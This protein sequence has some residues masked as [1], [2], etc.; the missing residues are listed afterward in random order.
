V[1]RFLSLDEVALTKFIDERVAERIADI[2]AEPSHR[3]PWLT[4]SEAADYLRT[5]PAAV[6]KRLKRGQLTGFHPEGSPILLHRG[7]LCGTGPTW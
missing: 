6:Y 5:T 4:V 2:P 7:H 3:S 1:L